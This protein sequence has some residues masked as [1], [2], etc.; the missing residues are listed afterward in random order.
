[1]L[2]HQFLHLDDSLFS[3]IRYFPFSRFSVI[4][5]KSLGSSAAASLSLLAFCT[6]S[7]ILVHSAS[8][9]SSLSRELNSDSSKLCSTMLV[10]VLLLITLSSAM[11]LL[12]QN[13][14]YL[15]RNRE[16]RYCTFCCIHNK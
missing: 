15:Y 10:L 4:S 1:M 8:S 7:C 14:E 6:S 16:K 3:I 12:L 2:C 13:S 5:L 11:Q 9:V